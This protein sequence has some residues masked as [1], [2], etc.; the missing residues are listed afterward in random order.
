MDVSA[1]L[2]VSPLL[3]D[4]LLLDSLGLTPLAAVRSLLTLLLDTLLCCSPLFRIKKNRLSGCLHHWETTGRPPGDHRETPGRPLGDH[5]ESTE[6]LFCC[7]KTFRAWGGEGSVV[8]ATVE[9]A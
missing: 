2:L 1:L 4:L 7:G 5:R 3:R 8:A 6:R 9:H